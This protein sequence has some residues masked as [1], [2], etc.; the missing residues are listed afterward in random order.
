[1]TS[2]RPL[3][4]LL[5]DNFVCRRGHKLLSRSYSAPGNQ[6]NAEY[7]YRPIRA[8][9]KYIPEKIRNFAIIA[10][11]DHGKSTLADRFLQLTNVIPA[12]S[13]AQYLD[14]LEVER[15]RGI[16]VKAQ[17][18]SMFYKDYMLNLVDTPGHVDFSFEVRRSL[19]TCDGALLLVA[20]N[21]GVQAQTMFNFHSAF[22]NNLTI[23]PNMFGF[24]ADEILKVSAKTGQNVQEL[25]EAIVQRIPPPLVKQEGACQ[26]HVFDSCFEHFKG[27][28][29]FVMVKQGTLIK[30]APIRF[31]SSPEREYIVTEVG[32]LHP[33]TTP[34]DALY[35]GQ[36][37]YIYCGI[38]SSRDVLI[39]DTLFH[40][41]TSVH[42]VKPYVEIGSVEPTVYSG[43]FPME[44][45]EYERLRM[46][47]SVVFGQG[48]RVGFV[49]NLHME[50]FGQRLE[51]EHGELAVFTTPSVKYL[52]DIVDNESIRKRRHK[53]NSQISICKPSDYPEVP[54]DVQ[55]FLEPMSLVSIVTPAEFYPNIEKLC[56]NARG[57]ALETAYIDE[58]QML[59][60]W[61]LPLVEI[62][63]DFFDGLKLATSGYASFEQ[64]D[65]GYR[66]CRLEKICIFVNDKPVDELSMLC[67]GVNVKARAEEVVKKLAEEI[68]QQQ[69]EIK[70]MKKD[71]TG[72]LK[73]NLVADRLGKKLKHQR[74]GKEKLKMVG[75]VKIPREAFLIVAKK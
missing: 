60:R 71:F 28:L 49:G 9:N 19:V 31:F 40:S 52:A 65:D 11:I 3:F 26:A 22:E 50:V 51:Q 29:L 55:R 35:A 30:N 47:S 6:G 73:G 34:S 17:T 5:Q 45:M 72:L 13:D 24:H 16:T 12:E 33:E 68:P 63:V 10:H 48:W 38:K 56:R 61:R 7:N 53:D 15:K 69:F 8:L 39:G 27:A 25:L 57:E 23:I 54:T 4:L 32:I 74:E 67:P 64:K 18:C 14:K 44:P 41:A 75:V 46:D 58:K 62:I 70:P 2:E 37:G 43:L 1:M 59:L 21:Q 36:M 66:E 20:A 42:N